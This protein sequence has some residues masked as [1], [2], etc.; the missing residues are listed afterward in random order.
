MAGYL[1]TSYYGRGAYG[2]QAA[3]RTYYGKDAKDLN[4]S[5]CAFLAALLKGADL[6]R[7]G[8]RAGHRPG[9]DAGGEHRRAPRSAGT[10]SSTRWSRTAS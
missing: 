2:I 9:G 5:Q 8:R 10:G 6:L 1:N 3:A 7:P 4:P